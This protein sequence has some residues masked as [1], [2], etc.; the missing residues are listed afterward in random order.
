MGAVDPN[1]ELTDVSLC[2]QAMGIPL[3]APPDQIER[4][5]RSLAGEYRK[6]M[7]S[8]DQTQREE[9][10]LS[11]ELLQEMYTKIQKSATYRTVHAESLKKRGTP[12]VAETGSKR[13]V[14]QAVA[15]RSVMV[16]CPRCNGSMAKGD[17]VC[18]ICKTPIQ[19]SYLTPKMMLIYMV[20]ASLALL[21]VFAIQYPEK[22]TETKAGLFNLIGQK[23]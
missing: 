14:H 8:P 13:P 6:K 2:Y 1:S 18:P 23:K 9:A 3:D 4:R 21:A 12:A 5:Y 22:F 7:T 16:H 15:R 19:M 11:L 17:K 10:R 20:A